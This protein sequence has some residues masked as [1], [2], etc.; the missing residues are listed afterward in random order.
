MNIKLVV[1]MTQSE[2][3]KAGTCAGGLQFDLATNPLL[4]VSPAQIE[5]VVVPETKTPWRK[6]GRLRGAVN[7][8]ESRSQVESQS[9]R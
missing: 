7:D 5:V 2:L 9:T 6:P 8:Q 3:D 4:D 1:E